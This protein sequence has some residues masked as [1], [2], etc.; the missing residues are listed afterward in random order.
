MTH[1][2]DHHVDVAKRW[3]AELADQLDLATGDLH[4]P[5]APR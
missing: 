3:L 5:A 1:T 4:G 2:F